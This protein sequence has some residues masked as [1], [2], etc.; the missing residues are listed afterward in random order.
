MDP[1][2]NMLTIIKNGYMARKQF[3]TVPYSVVK[4]KIAKKLLDAGFIEDVSLA[5]NKRNLRIDLLYNDKEPVV[6]ELKRV[7][8]PSLRIYTSSKK[9]PRVLRGRGEVILS[10]PKGILTGSEA[11]KIKVG[12]EILLKIW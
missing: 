12:G 7:S 9:I 5:E 6:S 4:E 10:T 2:S 8:K 11:R 1:I 3:V